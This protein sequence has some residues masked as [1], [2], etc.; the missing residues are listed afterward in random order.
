MS[1][2]TTSGIDETSSPPKKQLGVFRPY[3]YTTFQS[4]CSGVKSNVSTSTPNKEL[5]PIPTRFK[6][7]VEQIL[8]PF[9]E[10][11][12]EDLSKIASFNSIIPNIF[13]EKNDEFQLEKYLVDR[14]MFR[15]LQDAHIINWN[16]HL[17]RLFPI[18][19]SGKTR[20]SR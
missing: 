14:P 18:R 12:I 3:F 1:Q 9:N 2:S 13:L 15:M 16:Y 5:L 20:I 6:D 17:K 11:I 8:A 10:W 19:T 4:S 7:R